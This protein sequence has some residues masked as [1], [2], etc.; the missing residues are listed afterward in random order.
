M[1][2]IKKVWMNKDIKKSIALFFSSILPKKVPIIWA[3]QDGPRPKGSYITLKITPITSTESDEKINLP[4]GSICQISRAT[5]NLSIQ[6]FRRGAIDTAT[7][8]RSNLRKTSYTDKFYIDLKGKNHTLNIGMTKDVLETT[9]LIETNYEERAS[10]EITI[11]FAESIIDNGV[12]DC[13][14]GAEFPAII[15]G[16]YNKQADGDIVIEKITTIDK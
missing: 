5:F 9:G 1:K 4:D 13:G 14:L 10:L 12:K 3:E 16:Q 6:I 7:T 11:N 15:K 2:K 8:L